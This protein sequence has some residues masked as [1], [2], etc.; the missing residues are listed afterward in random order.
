MFRIKFRTKKSVGAYVYP[1]QEWSW[2]A[3]KIAIFREFI[4]NFVLQLNKLEWHSYFQQDRASAHSTQSTMASFNEVLGRSFDYQ[5]SVAC[6][7]F[8]I[9]IAW[10]F[11]VVF[12]DESSISHQTCWYRRT[13]KPNNPGDSFNRCSNLT[14]EYS[15]IWLNVLVDVLK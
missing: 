1:S 6:K 5:G 2:A 4:F 9:D 10:F 8:W 13:E 3:P 7:K 11:S 15:E 12:L 14:Q